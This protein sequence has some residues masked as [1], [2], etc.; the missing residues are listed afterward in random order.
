MSRGFLVHEPP[1]VHSSFLF[2]VQ[3]LDPSCF[4][5]DH[6]KTYDSISTFLSARF[7]FLLSYEPAD[8]SHWTVQ[9]LHL[10]DLSHRRHQACAHHQ[11]FVLWSFTG[12]SHF[13]TVIH[14]HFYLLGTYC[15]SSLSFL[16][17]VCY[18]TQAI[19]PWKGPGLKKRIKILIRVRDHLIMPSYR[20]D[21]G[22]YWPNYLNF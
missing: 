11:A 17:I 21:T 4:K 18:S 20:L 10:N 6:F 7:N 22:F 16:S 9:V 2:Q 14:C 3:I 15:M 8:V 13:K 19:R 5:R 12:S 1:V